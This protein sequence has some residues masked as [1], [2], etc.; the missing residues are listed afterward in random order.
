MWNFIKK[1]SPWICL[2]ALIPVVGFGELSRYYSRHKETDLQILF[3]SL[4]MVF[5]AI[6]LSSC[7][8]NLFL[9]PKK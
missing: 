2:F 3:F 8:I 9:R 6:Q 4:Q 5:L 7:Y 1:N